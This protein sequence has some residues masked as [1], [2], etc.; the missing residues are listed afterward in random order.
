MYKKWWGFGTS[1]ALEL[2]R[3]TLL[4]KKYFPAC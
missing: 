3:K 2:F 1:S 4:E